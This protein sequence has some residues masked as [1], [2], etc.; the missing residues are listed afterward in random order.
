[1][2]F[3]EIWSFSTTVAYQRHT[4]P[5]GD[6]SVGGDARIELLQNSLGKSFWW[7]T[8]FDVK[9]EVF[10]RSS[11]SSSSFGTAIQLGADSCN[12]PQSMHRSHV[13]INSYE[14]TLWH[15]RIHGI[16]LLPLLLLWHFSINGIFFCMACKN[17]TSATRI[18]IAAWYYFRSSRVPCAI[19]FF[20]SFSF[21]CGIHA[22][23]TPTNSI[24]MI[25]NARA[26]THS[27]NATGK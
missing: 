5:E 12:S 1:M 18:L 2:Y 15:I 27:K 7:S 22:T 24:Q 21:S 4:K 11:N 17:V 16:R 10:G 8:L 6:A 26:H 13:N 25:F 19:Q 23:V 9:I 20:L 3:E 14:C